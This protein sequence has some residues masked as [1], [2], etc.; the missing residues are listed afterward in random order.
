M[1][2]YACS[3]TAGGG[4]AAQ[5]QKLRQVV[6]ALSKEQERLDASAAA[7]AAC[8]IVDEDRGVLLDAKA[9]EKDEWLVH[10]HEKRLVEGEL[11]DALL[12]LLVNEATVDVARVMQ[13]QARRLGR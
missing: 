3:K 8:A 11:G 12:A 9:A 5:R 6:G 1:Y 13:K 10:Q 4:E 2:D 7:S